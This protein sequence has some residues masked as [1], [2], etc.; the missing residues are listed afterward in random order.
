MIPLFDINLLP[1]SQAQLEEGALLLRGFAAAEAPVLIDE[2]ARIAQT[3]AF[4]HMVI[5]SHTATALPSFTSIWE[6]YAV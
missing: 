6:P 1:R 3:A 5:H 2:V 4:R